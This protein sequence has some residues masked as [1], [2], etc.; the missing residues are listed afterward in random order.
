[1]LTLHH[2][3]KTRSSRILWLLEE[4]GAPY[5]LVVHDYN[6]PSAFP[7][8]YRAIHPHKKVPALVHDGVVITESAAICCYLA[9]AFPAAEL[10]PRIGDPKRGPF[11]TWLSYNAG[12]LEPAFMA[13]IKG[14]DADPRQVAW[15]SFDDAARTLREALSAGPYVLGER[16]SAADVLIATSVQIAGFRG[17]LLPQEEPF[18][19]YVARIEARPAYQRALAKDAG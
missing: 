4:I 2:S 17:K 10:G 13:K 9:D 18:T 16:F 3:P 8:E 14:W 1:M 12:V 11:L 15:G 5:E 19:G 6:A 7:E